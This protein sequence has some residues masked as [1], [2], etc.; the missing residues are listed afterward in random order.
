MSIEINKLECKRFG[1]IAARWTDPNASPD[2]IDTEAL[3]CRADMVSTRVDVADLGQVHALEGSGYR[4]MDTLVYYARS[5]NDLP[6]HAIGRTNVTLRRASPEDRSAVAALAQSAFVNYIGHYHSD[7]RL[8]NAA[9]D[10]AYVEWAETATARTTDDTP[11]FLVE[12]G[13]QVA[14]FLTMRRNN[15]TEFEIVLNAVHPDSQGKGLYTSLVVDALKYAKSVGAHRLIISTQI[16]NYAVQKAWS[17]L[18]FS[19][20]RSL[21]TFHKWFT[22]QSI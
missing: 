22:P 9:A 11:V 14:G 21:Y 13:N 16:N 6:D 10:A 15:S 2:Q 3:R 1:I 19:H 8:D 20:Y 12:S 4:L 5:L 17:K 7:P 18:G